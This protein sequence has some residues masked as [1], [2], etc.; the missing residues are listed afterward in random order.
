MTVPRS[1]NTGERARVLAVGG[2][3]DLLTF[4]WT[5]EALQEL[6]I[7]GVVRADAGAPDVMRALRPDIA[8]VYCETDAEE[9]VLELLGRM[10]EDG[11]HRCDVLLIVTRP[12]PE[13]VL[14]V[15]R[16]GVFSCLVAPVEPQT[17]RNLM[18]AWLVRWRLKREAPE[19]L[20]EDL[21]DDRPADP[22]PRDEPRPS[23]TSTLGLVATALR[24]N[25]GPLSAS[26]VG[27]LCKLSAVASRRYLKQLVD[28]GSAVMTVQY[29]KT[30]RPRH[31]YG[32][33]AHLMRG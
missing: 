21:L 5:V 7:A 2:T 12:R 3:D 6:E 10:R 14:A 22:G 23:T 9:Q 29:G 8:L 32:W 25:P 17:L 28:R 31:L 30:G 4:L 1:T 13:L 19:H 27:E 18:E 24:D 16:S 20:P 15:A 11:R 26:E 33:A